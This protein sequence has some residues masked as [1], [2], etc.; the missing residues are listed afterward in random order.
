MTYRLPMLTAA[1][2]RAIS[3]HI[4]RN[5]R[6]PPPR[7]DREIVSALLYARAASCS[8][9]ALPKGY[10][11]ADSIRTRVR[12]WEDAGVLDEIVAAGRSAQGR[13]Q[14]AFHRRL[15]ELSFT[16]RHRAP[17]DPE[18]ANLPDKKRHVAWR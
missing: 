4:P 17:D 9:E 18:R 13:M 6:G 10:P 8:F 3:A 5:K 12:R 11:S 7:H 16:P 14:I 2:W 1:E 15:I